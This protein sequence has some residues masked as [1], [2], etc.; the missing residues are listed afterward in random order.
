MC[1]RAS[2]TLDETCGGDSFSW[3]QYS[4]P[5]VESV[6]SW[7]LSNNTDME[8]SLSWPYL[9]VRSQLEVEC[10]HDLHAMGLVFNPKKT[11]AIDLPTVTCRRQVGTVTT[12]SLSLTSMILFFP[13]S[14]FMSSPPEVGWLTHQES[15]GGF[16][17]RRSTLDSCPWWP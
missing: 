17:H 12:L 14:P 10:M 16:R 3:F 15:P 5:G 2:M 8:D 7:H 9:W 13:S 4:V 1:G 6:L 11:S